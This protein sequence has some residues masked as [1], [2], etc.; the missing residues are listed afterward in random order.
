MQPFRYYL[1]V[2]YSECDAQKVVFNG[3]YGEYVDLAVTEFTRAAG[4]NQSGMFGDF[5]YQ[6]VKQTTEWKAPIRF[7]QVVEVA[8]QTKHIGTTSFS[9]LAEFRIAGMDDVTASI[10][11]VYVNVDPKE[12]VKKPISETLRQALTRG[13][14]DVQVDHAGYL[15]V[16]QPRVV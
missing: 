14:P 4:L 2:R 8:V 3:R 7:D 12:L 6:V 5:D 10:E 1:R 13:A 15:S 9:L 16:A 11:T